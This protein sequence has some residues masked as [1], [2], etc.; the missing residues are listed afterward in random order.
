MSS[1]APFTNGSATRWVVNAVLA[2]LLTLV[3]YLA[4]A[5][6]GRIADDARTALQV[7]QDNRRD[8]AVLKT[9]ERRLEGIE[10]NQERLLEMF[11]RHLTLDSPPGPMAR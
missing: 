2:S 8:I 1:P 4:G 11:Q 5:D 7:A 9:V 6:R 10:S 3:A